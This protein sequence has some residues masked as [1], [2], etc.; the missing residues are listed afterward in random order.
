VDAP[1]GQAAAAGGPPTTTRA[2]PLTLPAGTLLIVRLTGEVSSGVQKTG[3]RFQ[4]N[5]DNDLVAGGQLVA[6]RGAR[7]YG[8][9]AQVVAGTGTGTAPVLALELTDIEVAGRVVPVVTSRVQAQGEAKKAGKKVLG[10][11]ALGAGIGAA[12][13][14]GEGAAWGA[15]IGAVAGAAAAKKSPGNQ[16]A[17]ASASALEF[18]TQQPLTVEK[19]VTVQAPGA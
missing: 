13:D 4:G 3:D 16:V 2:V 7:V 11:A 5:L 14:G 19:L 18:R 12:I 6:S 9:V 17:F 8:R 10:G 15:G 1:G